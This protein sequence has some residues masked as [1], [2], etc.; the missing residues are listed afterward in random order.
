MNGIRKENLLSL[1]VGHKSVAD[2]DDRKKWAPIDTQPEHANCNRRHGARYGN[3]KRS[4]VAKLPL[5]T[6]RKW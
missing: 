5:R 2:L 3:A 4:V 1:D 6:S